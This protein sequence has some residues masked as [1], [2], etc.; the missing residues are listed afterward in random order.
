MQ[1]YYSDILSTYNMI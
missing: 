1:E